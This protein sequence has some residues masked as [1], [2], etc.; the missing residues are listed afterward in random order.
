MTRDPLLIFDSGIGGFS[1][2]KEILHYEIPVHY[3]A[4]Q[5]NFPYGTKSTQFITERLREL[6]TIWLK[7]H[8]SAIVLACNT[9]TVTAIKH[10]RMLTDLPIFGVEPVI[11]MLSHHIHPVIWGTKR[12][13]ALTKKTPHL[14]H[15]RFYT[16]S[17]L[18]SAIESHDLAKI[19]SILQIAKKALPDVDAIGLSCTHYPL[20]KDQ[21]AAYFPQAS[22]Y[23]PSFAVAKH[24]AQ[25]LSLEPQKSHTHS[26]IQFYSTLDVVRLQQAANSYN[27]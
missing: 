3:F 9:G 26:P 7:Q 22:I 2:L 4:D 17:D 15:I 27:I 5:A 10:L 16:P 18:A 6:T 21:I 24:I 8:Y 25:S 13:I 23:D 12:T 14:D 11:N 20:I 1:I 19:N